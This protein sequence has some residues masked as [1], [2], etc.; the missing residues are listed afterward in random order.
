MGA[1]EAKVQ[2]KKSKVKKDKD[3]PEVSNEF[4]FRR[5]IDFFVVLSATWYSYLTAVASMM[6]VYVILFR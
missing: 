1:E 4:L 6:H 2:I 5:S 3:D